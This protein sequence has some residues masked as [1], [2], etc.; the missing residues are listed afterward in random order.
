MAERGARAGDALAAA[1]AGEVAG[2]GVADDALTAAGSAGCRERFVLRC[3]GHA[4]GQP[5]DG[6]RWCRRPYGSV[7]ASI[8]VAMRQRRDARA[9]SAAPAYSDGCGDVG[10]V[11][12]CGAGSRR[13]ARRSAGW[14]GQLRAR[15]LHSC[16]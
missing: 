8:V 10:V 11:A 15:G 16:F 3:R 9:L 14:R 13:A 5:T 7:G 12:E 6:L 1:G 2:V 4:E